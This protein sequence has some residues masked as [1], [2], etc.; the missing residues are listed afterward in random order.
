MVRTII[1]PTDTN[2]QLSISEE[3]IGKAIEITY[4]ALEELEQT[5]TKKTMADFKGILTANEADQLQD[6]VT[7]SREEWSRNS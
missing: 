5:S 6:Y 4:L 2:I 3:Y 1:T 7:K